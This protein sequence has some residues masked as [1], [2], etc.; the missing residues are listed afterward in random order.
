[1]NKR[2]QAMN[3]EELRK[4]H[5]R[6]FKKLSSEKRLEWAFTTAHSIRNGLSKEAR[7][8]FDSFKLKEKEERNARLAKVIEQINQ[9]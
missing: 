8:R 7:T 1:M 6:N 5:I 9:K 3:S 4:Q 2:N